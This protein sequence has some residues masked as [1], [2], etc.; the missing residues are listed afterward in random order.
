[1]EITLLLEYSCWNTQNVRSS[2]PGCRRITPRRRSAGLSCPGA[3]LP[4]L[5]FLHTLMSWKKLCA[6][7]GLT[8]HS[9]SF[10]MADSHR[11]FPL[12]ARTAIGPNLTWTDVWISKIVASSP[13]GRCA[14]ENAC[15]W[16]YQV[17]H[18]TPEQ[19]EDLNDHRK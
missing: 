6:S 15:G 19:L 16:R 8:V 1:M 9:R 4:H 11:D 18:P 12:A 17:F 13:S 3:R 2:E 10:L 5:I 14:F 7:D